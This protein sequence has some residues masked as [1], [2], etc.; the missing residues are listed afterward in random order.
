MKRLSHKQQQ[1]LLNKSRRELLRRK[2]RNKHKARNSLTNKSTVLQKDSVSCGNT[3]IATAPNNFSI[4]NNS[5]ET[6]KYFSLVHS[7]IAKANPKD[8]IFFDFSHVENLTADAIMYIIALMN[9]DKKLNAFDIRCSGNIPASDAA[10]RLMEECGFYQYVRSRRFINRSTTNDRIKIHRGQQPEND[11]AKELCEFVWDKSQ[12]VIDRLSTKRLFAVIIE[13]MYNACQHA[14][15]IHSN[16]SMFGNWYSYAEDLDGIVRF[17]F[18]DTGLGIP[19]T[20]KKTL[21]EKAKD[22][23]WDN[24]SGYIASALRGEHR[25]QTGNNYRGKGLPEILESVTDG[26]MRSLQIFSGKGVCYVEA[27]GNIIEQNLEYTFKGTMYVWE[28]SKG[29]VT[30]C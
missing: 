3:Y 28:I 18:F 25:T 13:M 4:R 7:L 17:V 11:F 16:P 9:N 10:K 2:K 30:T 15:D 14:Y 6:V 21:L 1:W 8:Q 19:S 29:G 20:I 12:G 22:I 27:D 23:I 24:D 5:D 26:S